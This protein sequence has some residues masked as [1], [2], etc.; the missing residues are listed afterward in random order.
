MSIEVSAYTPEQVKVIVNGYLTGETVEQL[1]ETSGKNVRSV[2]AKLAR[3]G[4][5]IAKPKKE[6]TARPTKEEM[7]I[8]I[9]IEMG[10]DPKQLQ[11]FEKATYPALSSL[12]EKIKTCS[13]H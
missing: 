9:C 12:H 6:S 7:L 1:A 13:C 4:V 8:S 10:L 3:E 2:I 5:Y 11:S